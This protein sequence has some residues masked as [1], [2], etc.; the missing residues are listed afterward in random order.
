MGALT[1]ADHDRINNWFW[2]ANVFFTAMLNDIV[3]NQYGPDW[4]NDNFVMNNSFNFVPVS[5]STRTHPPFADENGVPYDGYTSNQMASPWTNTRQEYTGYIHL[6]GLL[7]N[8]EPSKFLAKKMFVNYLRFTVGL[9]YVQQEQLRLYDGNDDQGTHYNMVTVHSF[10][11]MAYLD[12]VAYFNGVQGTTN[13]ES[14]FIYTF[15][16]S[17][18]YSSFP[19]FD[20]LAGSDTAY[21]DKTLLKVALATVKFEQQNNGAFGW[22]P[23][24]YTNTTLNTLVN[25]NQGNERPLYPIIVTNMGYNNPILKAAYMGDTSIGFEPRLAEWEGAEDAGNWEMFEGPWGAFVGGGLGVLAE[26]EGQVFPVVVE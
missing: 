5:N 9:N 12:R 13:E 16:T 11:K 4:V 14:K 15:S 2:E 22:S 10:G 23:K 26:L 25:S 17:E 24:F 7:Y 20:G 8:H 1:Q 6:Y 18:G 3:G 21:P 19:A